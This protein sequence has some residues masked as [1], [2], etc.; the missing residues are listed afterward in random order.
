MQIRYWQAMKAL[1]QSVAKGD[2][3]IAM[4][5]LVR[6]TE[7]RAEEIM[8]KGV[9]ILGAELPLHQHT[10]YSLSFIISS[11]YSNAVTKSLLL[12]LGFYAS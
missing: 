10:I 12:H 9:S 11:F 3:E 6:S 8:Y 2:Q 7:Y 5:D 1:L 4:H